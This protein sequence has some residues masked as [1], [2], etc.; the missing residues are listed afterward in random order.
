MY[1]A[2]L[3]AQ[4]FSQT[5]GIDYINSHSPVSDEVILRLLIA[6]KG[7]RKLEG[8]TFEVETAFLYVKL[9]EDIFMKIPEGFEE[10]VG[11][12]NT[13]NVLKVDGATYGLVQAARQ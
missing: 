12:D 8:V 11:S 6:K 5:P 2:C 3:V 10:V 4:G 1:C 13:F 9:E 7:V